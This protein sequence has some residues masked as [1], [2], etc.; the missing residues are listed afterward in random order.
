M[1]RRMVYMSRW[2]GSQT[3]ESHWPLVVSCAGG[4]ERQPVTSVPSPPC[5]G[6]AGVHGQMGELRCVGRSPSPCPKFARL[7]P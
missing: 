6:R 7:N 3:N 1:E 2:W 5:P 4:G